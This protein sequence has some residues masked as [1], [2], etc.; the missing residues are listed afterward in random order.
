LQ[1][2]STRKKKLKKKL[3]KKKKKKKKKK[4]ER[5]LKRREACNCVSLLVLLG[6]WEFLIFPLA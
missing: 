3:K 6:L 4:E 2:A 5:C 1:R